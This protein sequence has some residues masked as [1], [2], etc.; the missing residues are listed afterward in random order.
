[1]KDTWLKD[2]P[3]RWV[4]SGV[5]Q[6]VGSVLLVQ[7]NTSLLQVWLSKENV[8]PAFLCNFQKQHEQHLLESDWNSF[9]GLGH[10]PP[11]GRTPI[12]LA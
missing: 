9:L 8:V 7:C 11:A 12:I 5:D 2:T 3:Q 4:A 6:V 10:L 1:M